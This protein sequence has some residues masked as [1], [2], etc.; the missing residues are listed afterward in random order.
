MKNTLY[1]I[2]LVLVCVT[3]CTSVSHFE[4]N[5]M[6]KLVEKYGGTV[7]IK[8]S[9]YSKTVKEA[10]QRMSKLERFMALSPDSL[11]IQSSSSQRNRS[12]VV[13]TGSIDSFFCN[14]NKID[15]I[16]VHEISSPNIHFYT[17]TSVDK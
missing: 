2:L 3:S 13:E 6:H 7:S 12:G 14:K 17:C 11:I 4:D 9:Y 10:K 16:K 15:Y 5:S 1:P 8:P